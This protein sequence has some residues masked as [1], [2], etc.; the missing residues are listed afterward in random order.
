MTNLTASESSLLNGKLNSSSLAA[1][2]WARLMS[3]TATALIFPQQNPL[4]CIDRPVDHK[5][6]NQMRYEVM[7]HEARR[8]S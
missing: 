8:L 5:L 6:H 4:R 1:R 2:F 7:R 3:I